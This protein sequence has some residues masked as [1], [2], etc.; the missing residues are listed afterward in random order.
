M[1]QKLQTHLAGSN[2]ADFEKI[3][4]NKDSLT[5]IGYDTAEN[6]P[7][8]NWKILASIANMLAN[9]TE[10][11]KLLRTAGCAAQ[12]PMKADLSGAQL[13]KLTKNR[14][15][16]RLCRLP[17]RNFR[18][19][20]GMLHT[21]AVDHLRAPSSFVACMDVC[22]SVDEY[23]VWASFLWCSFL[24]MRLGNVCIGVYECDSKLY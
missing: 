10:P 18:L 12:L 15:L 6:D 3:L 1:A 16:C 9:S 17:P 20:N 14:N 23:V 13:R 7:S 2:I 5:R 22:M 8:K 11:S 19:W 24:T 4:Q 21:S